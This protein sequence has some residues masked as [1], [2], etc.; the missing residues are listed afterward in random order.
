MTWFDEQDLTPAPPPLQTLGSMSPAAP[1]Q[2]LASVGAARPLHPSRAALASAPARSAT[3]ADVVSPAG[4]T[5]RMRGPDG[6]E[7]AVALEDVPQ[8]QAAGAWIIG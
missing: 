7:G 2:T 4:P 8:A 1:V 3:P 5:V 6:A